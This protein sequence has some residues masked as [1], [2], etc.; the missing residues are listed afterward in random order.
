M[1]TSEEKKVREKKERQVECCQYTVATVYGIIFWAGLIAISVYTSVWVYDNHPGEDV[2]TY[3][4]Y[5]VFIQ[6][7]QAISVILSI[8]TPICICCIGCTS[9]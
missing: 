5:F 8:T 3:P 4:P 7:V 6:W 1:L 9:D 2:K